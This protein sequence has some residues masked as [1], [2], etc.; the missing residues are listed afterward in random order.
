MR[1]VGELIDL[2]GDHSSRRGLDR[3]R[4]ILDQLSE[5]GL[6]ERNASRAHYFRANLASLERHLDP[7]GVGWAWHNEL[8]GEEV[9]QLRHAVRHQGFSALGSI[10]RAQALTNLGNALNHAGRFI[11]AIELWERAEAEVPG[12]AMALGNR[13]IGLA[14][15]AGAVHDPGHEAVLLHSAYR[16]LGRAISRDAVWDSIAAPSTRRQLARRREEVGAAFDMDRFEADLDLDGFP[17]GRGRREKEY[18]TWCLTNRLFVNPLNDV[19]A[20]SIAARDVMVLPTITT[21][22]SDGPG[23]PAVVQHFNIVKQEFCAARYAM[24]EARTTAGIHFSDRG[25]LL[26]DTLDYPAIGFAVERMKM[27]FRGAYAVFDKT[28]FL[29]N[30]FL[31]LGHHERR[32]SFRNLWFE[33]GR[34]GR[35]HEALEERPNWPLRGLYWLSKDIFEDGFRNAT[36]P[37]AEMLY[38][39][40]N[41][42]EHKF[43]SVH[44]LLLRP[45]Y[46]PSGGTTGS[47]VLAISF[48]D[49][50]ARTLRQMKL[51]RATLVYMALA[52]HS[53]ERRRDVARGEGLIYGQSVLATFED[54]WKFRG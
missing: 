22:F 26:Y 32:V 40:R 41:H 17:L 36:E 7:L 12:F 4:S 51:A 11:E 50:E 31:R 5:K 43:V 45:T 46:P 42:M 37:D 38:D 53:E 44:D 1:H 18:R 49:L 54:G 24:F 23:I 13:G 10:E 6:S 14:H 25:V 48:D 35:I 20:H 28:A 9:I 30:A 34:E 2:S 29:L 47:G 8:L 19:G 15:Y 39:L 27:A 3:A 33:K 21:S 52:I 16:S